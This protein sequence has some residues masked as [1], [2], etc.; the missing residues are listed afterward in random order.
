MVG[1]KAEQEGRRY[2]GDQVH[3]APS[4]ATARVAGQAAAPGAR[5][6]RQALDEFAVAND[7][8]EEREEE[9]ESQRHVV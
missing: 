9:A 4:V 5:A 3:R 6:D 8:G 7:D 1:Q 2:H